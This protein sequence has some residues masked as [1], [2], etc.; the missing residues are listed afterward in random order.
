MLQHHSHHQGKLKVVVV[1]VTVVRRWSGPGR[2]AGRRDGRGPRPGRRGTRWP[3]LP[4]LFLFA[5]VNLEEERGRYS[6][7]EWS[8][9]CSKH[10][11]AT[12]QAG[13]AR[14]RSSD[15]R[16]GVGV[17]V[18]QVVQEGGS[19]FGKV[20]DDGVFEHLVVIERL[21]RV[22]SADDGGDVGVLV[23]TQ[24]FRARVPREKSVVADDRLLG[25]ADLFGNERE[26]LKLC[27]GLV[28]E[29][30]ARF[31]EFAVI[32]EGVAQPRGETVAGFFNFFSMEGEELL[33]VED[34]AAAGLA[35]RRV[36]SL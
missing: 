3:C 16:D 23:Q 2:R 13:E 8:V 15:E 11:A 26:Q 6:A 4:G 21:D 14:R 33:D 36:K 19:L 5:K 22:V 25:F 27:V 35:Q 1:V 17:H 34:W 20:L 7:A 31:Y 29:E 28:F 10:Q 18:S 30:N 32:V 9:E 24:T 12:P